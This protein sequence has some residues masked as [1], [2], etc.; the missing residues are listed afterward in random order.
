MALEKVL[1]AVPDK[2]LKN[3]IKGLNVPDAVGPSFFDHR[4]ATGECFAPLVVGPSFS[5]TGPPQDGATHHIQ[6]PSL[7][8]QAAQVASA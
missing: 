2:P 7:V 4:R 8:A 3:R 5:K 6:K 1:A